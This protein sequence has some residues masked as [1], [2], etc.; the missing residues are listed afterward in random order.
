MGLAIVLENENGQK[1]E[2]VDDPTNILHKLLPSHD[3]ER[4]NLLTFIDWYGDTTF[5]RLQVATVISELEL[6]EREKAETTEEKMLIHN[7]LL[8]AKKSQQ[9]P[10]FYLKFYGD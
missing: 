2:R 8:L 6:I 3:D 10:H 7:I 5:N 1:I 4:Y 9:A